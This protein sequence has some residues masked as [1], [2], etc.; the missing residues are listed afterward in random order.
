MFVKVAVGLKVDVG[1]RVSV[2]VAVGGKGGKGKSVVVKVSVRVGVGVDQID[3]MAAS[4]W[5]KPY[6]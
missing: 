2:Y 1:W 5:I 3:W 6:P 4:I